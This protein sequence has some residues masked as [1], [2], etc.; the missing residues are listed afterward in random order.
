MFSFGL[1]VIL[2]KKYNLYTGKVGFVSGKKDILPLLTTLL[3]NI[4]GT[5]IGSGIYRALGIKQERLGAICEAK[6]SNEWWQVLLL[7]ILCGVMMYLA[8][9]L[10][11]S[12]KNPLMVMMPISVF[13][14]CG[15]EHSMASLFYFISNYGLD[16]FQPK[17]IIYLLIMVIG[18]AI[19]SLAWRFIEVK[20]KTE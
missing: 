8:V 7:A 20:E 3:G 17:I 15:F 10:F 4:I 9:S 6:L 14:M 13:I 18:N 5:A 11:R 19:G 2:Y 12:T 16:I 1:L